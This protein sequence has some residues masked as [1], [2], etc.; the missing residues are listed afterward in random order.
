MAGTGYWC[1]IVIIPGKHRRAKVHCLQTIWVVNT[2]AKAWGTAA[3]GYH[4]G[5]QQHPSQALHFARRQSGQHGHTVPCNSPSALPSA[6]LWRCAP[7]S[8]IKAIPFPLYYFSRWI[9]CD[10]LSKAYLSIGVSKARI[11]T[12]W[13]PGIRH[14]VKSLQQECYGQLIMTANIFISATISIGNFETNNAYLLSLLWKG[15]ILFFHFHLSVSPEFLPS[16]LEFPSIL[17]SHC[18]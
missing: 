18:P 7:S 1:P 5:C 2:L 16:A 12:L 13:C 3:A 17:L 6:L 8:Q 14:G 11:F 10:L 9:L 4:A 15:L